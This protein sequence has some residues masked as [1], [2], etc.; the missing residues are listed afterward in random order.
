[1][2][3]ATEKQCTKCGEVKPLAAFR[4]QPEG[5][6]GRRADC[7]ACNRT[8][9]RA[10]TQLHP[11]LIRERSRAYNL[12]NPG[13]SAASKDWE[14]RHRDERKAYKAAWR[15][16]NR[17]RL[18]LRDSSEYVRQR[19]VRESSQKGHV[20]RGIKKILLDRQGM[21]CVAP[22]CG[23]AIG[24]RIN[25][26]IDCHLDHIVPLALGGLHDDANLQVMCAACNHSKGYRSPEVFARE[27][28]ML[29]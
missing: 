4:K 11:E 3:D 6:L 18:A 7:Q 26:Q 23:I 5:K 8:Y 17:E 25:G 2:A 21:A 15:V 19:R 13:Q 28:G 27:R 20:S 24:K 29:L 14:M 9:A 22:G 12:A 10:Y 1:M 16:A